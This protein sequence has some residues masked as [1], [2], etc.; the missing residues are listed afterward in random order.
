MTGVLRWALPLACTVFFYGMAGGFWKQSTLLYGQF[1]VLFFAVKT[2]TNLGTW[3]VGARLNPFS[4]QRRGFVKW[5]LF[6]QFFNGMAWICYFKA[7]STGPAAIVQTITAAYT[8]LTVILA[9]LFLKERLVAIQ[10]LGVAMV[11]GSSVTLGLGSGPSSGGEGNIW[12]FA[13]LGTLFCW[14]VCTAIFK[15][16]YNQEGANDAVFFLT[17]WVGIGVTVLPFGLTQLGT[18]LWG[19]GLGLGLVIV[20]FYCI[21]D[22]TLFAAINRGPASIVSPLSGLYPIPTIA[23]SALILKEQITRL[24]WSTVG[25]VLMALIFIVPAED[26]PV[27]KLLGRSKSSVPVTLGGSVDQFEIEEES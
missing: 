26:N 2:V 8:A 6:G 12:F 15:H 4:A 10:V 18:E 5:A 27:L 19:G 13:S 23:Y 7:L 25:V 9:L 3:T 11:I 1:C 22:L 17:N 21:G 14:G 20:L 24:Q 16:A